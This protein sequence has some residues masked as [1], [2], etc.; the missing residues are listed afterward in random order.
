MFFKPDVIQAEWMRRAIVEESLLVSVFSFQGEKKGWKGTRCPLHP[1]NRMSTLLKARGFL[2]FFA[3]DGFHGG[4]E[5]VL[6]YNFRFQISD[7]LG[8]G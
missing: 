5:V 6:L 3:E 1:V 2:V 4:V 8:A 7:F